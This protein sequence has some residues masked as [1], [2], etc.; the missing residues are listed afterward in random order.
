MINSRKLAGMSA[1]LGVTWALAGGALLAPSTASAAECERKTW[2]EQPKVV[3]HTSEFEGT[4]TA[5]ANM[6]DAITD[7]NEQL[8]GV[9][10][11][12]AAV[13]ATQVSTDPFTQDTRFDVSEPTIHVGFDDTLSDPDAVGVTSRTLFTDT[14]ELARVNI[15]FLNEWD[16][17][18]WRYALPGGAG[19]NYYEAEEFVGGDGNKYFRVA[20]MHELLHAYGLVHDDGAEKYSFMNYGTRPW[21]NRP[22]DEMIKPLPADV[23][24]LRDLYP[25]DGSRGEVAVLNTWHG[26]G[27][28]RNGTAIQGVVCAPSLGSNWSGSVFDAHCGTG[29]P[30]SGSTDVCAGDMLRT[31]VTFANYSTDPVTIG[32]WLV[33]SEDE[34]FDPP[35][36]DPETPTEMKTFEL[37]AAHSARRG[38]AWEVPEIDAPSRSEYHPIVYVV[39]TPTNDDADWAVRSDW[40]PLPGTVEVC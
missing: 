39:A 28:P 18:S 21:A 26:D 34:E 40:I 16:G 29:G 5:Q 10:A 22:A 1:A 8:N 14:C 12:A 38:F 15:A 2:D 31:R 27:E 32:A 35:S 3:I 19:D 4:E 13:T 30:S 24:L 23:R 36:T 25:E 7:V 6:I 20:Y 33:F 37:G 9:G 11:T 17:K